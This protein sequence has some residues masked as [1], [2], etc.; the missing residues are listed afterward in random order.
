MRISIPLSVKI[1][2]DLLW[3]GGHSQTS[4]ELPP[5][6]SCSDLDE[7]AIREKG[8]PSRWRNAQRRHVTGLEDLE[9]T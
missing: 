6:K 5:A 8:Y 3:E 1:S 2:T 9:L 4:L 7:D